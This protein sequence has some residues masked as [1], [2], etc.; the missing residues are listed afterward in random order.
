MGS[1]CRAMAVATANRGHGRAHSSSVDFGCFSTPAERRELFFLFLFFSAIG[2]TANAASSAWE[3]ARAQGGGPTPQ[4]P[5]RE[6]CR[7]SLC[8][9]LLDFTKYLASLTD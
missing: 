7:E 1:H 8:A 6:V 2:P 9:P 5:E 4:K 3:L